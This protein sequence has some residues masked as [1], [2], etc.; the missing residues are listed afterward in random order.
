METLSALLY[1]WEG[2]TPASDGL[3]QIASIAALD[4]VFDGYLIKR[5]NKQLGGQWYEMP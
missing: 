3:T 5:L 4:Y 2:N 1:F